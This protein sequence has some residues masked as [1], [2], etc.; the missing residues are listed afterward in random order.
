M[1]DFP[2]V[3]VAPTLE[4]ARKAGKMLKLSTDDVVFVGKDVRRVEGLRATRDRTIFIDPDQCGWSVMR[5]LHDT[6]IQ[7]D[8]KN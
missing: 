4:R 5:S 3:V 2:I 8:R 6:F 1:S 7:Y